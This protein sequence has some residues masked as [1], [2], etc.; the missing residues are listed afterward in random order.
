MLTC[1]VCDSRLDWRKV[2][3]LGGETSSDNGVE[4]W[5][6]PGCSITLARELNSEGEVVDSA[7]LPIE[8]VDSKRANAPNP[9]LDRIRVAC[10]AMMELAAC[11]CRCSCT[12]KHSPSCDV[13]VVCDLKDAMQE[14]WPP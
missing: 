14:V 11:T 4:L 1:P 2:T 8:V 12:D 7:I 10:E 6:C 3:K 13:C 5:R 9:A